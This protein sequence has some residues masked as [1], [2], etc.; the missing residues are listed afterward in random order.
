MD[1]FWPVVGISLLFGGYGTASLVTNGMRRLRSLPGKAVFAAVTLI[2]MY[3]VVLG[4]TLLGLTLA[5]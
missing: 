2:L 4:G 1:H 5:S 3:Y